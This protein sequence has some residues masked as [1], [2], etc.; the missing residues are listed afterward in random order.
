MGSAGLEPSRQILSR[1]ALTDL[2]IVGHQQEPI[3]VRLDPSRLE[4]RHHELVTRRPQGGPCKAKARVE[5]A[6]GVKG[7]SASELGL[8]NQR[9]GAAAGRELV[10]EKKPLE[11][12]AHDEDVDRD[13]P[14][15]QKKEPGPVEPGP[16]S[17]N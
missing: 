6:M 9:T 3:A 15:L 10:E 4:K 2:H 16:C 14:A 7:L 13:H 12:T 1:R 11:A 8:S 17:F 5:Q